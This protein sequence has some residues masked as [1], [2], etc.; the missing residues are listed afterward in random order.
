[1]IGSSG[2]VTA[3]APDLPPSIGVGQRELSATMRRHTKA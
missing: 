1:M 2:A 3:P